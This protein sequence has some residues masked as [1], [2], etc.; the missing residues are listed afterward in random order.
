MPATLFAP[1]GLDCLPSR[2]PPKQKRFPRLEAIL[3]GSLLL[4]TTSGLTHSPIQTGSQKSYGSLSMFSDAP[5]NQKKIALYQSRL[6]LTRKSLHCH[7]GQPALNSLLFPPAGL[8]IPTLDLIPSILRIGLFPT[9]PPTPKSP[10]I[11]PRH[12][13]S[14]SYRPA[15]LQFALAR[16]QLPLLPSRRLDDPHS[17]PHSVYS[18]NWSL[19]HPTSD[20][21]ITANPSTAPFLR[22]LGNTSD[23]PNT[24]FSLDPE[25]DTISLRIGHSHSPDPDGFPTTPSL[26]SASDLSAALA[27]LLRV[28][29]PRAR[30]SVISRVPDSPVRRPP[31]RGVHGRYPPRLAPKLTARY[32]C[33]P[34]YPARQNLLEL[35]ANK[36]NGP[37]HTLSSPSSPPRAFFPFFLAG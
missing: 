26:S 11:L 37:I 24:A 21:E 5:P 25:L 22:V 4:A 20:P 18:K 9:P 17:R 35:N 19:P 30:A 1:T 31:R 15:P 29:T 16:P 10:Q 34:R 36:K 2:L 28:P 23:L 27:N 3:S 32:E 7:F 33:N 8:T 13:F 6:G 14:V 12:L